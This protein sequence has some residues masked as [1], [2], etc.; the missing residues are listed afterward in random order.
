MINL[1]INCNFL[2]IILTI[3]MINDFLFIDQYFLVMKLVINTTYDNLVRRMR[4]H[5]MVY[6][7][8]FLFEINKI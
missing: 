7:F 6:F 1:T 4:F 8:A 3:L 5:K 2:F